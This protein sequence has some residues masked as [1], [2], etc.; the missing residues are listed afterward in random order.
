VS[1][2]ERVTNHVAG[3]EEGETDAVHPSQ[4]FDRV[5]QARLLVLWQVDLGHVA[6]NDRGRAEADAGQEHLHLLDRRVLRLVE[7]DERIVERAAAH[8]RQRRDLDD[9]L[10]QQLDDFLHAEHLVQRVVQRAQ[11]GVDFLG[12]VAGQEAELL[13]GF[14]R[15]ADQDQAL[16]AGFVERFD[17]HR[18]REEGLAGTCRADA[19]VDVMR[20]DRVQVTALVRAAATHGA[21]FDLDRDVLRFDVGRRGGACVGFRQAQVDRRCGKE[22]AGRVV[23]QLAQQP[24]RAADRGVLAGDAE[25]VAA[26]GDFHAVAQF[27]QPQVRIERAAEVGQ[28]LGV[29]GVER[30]FGGAGRVA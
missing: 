27:Q 22:F 1:W 11:V 16:H 24:F 14:D 17:R 25:D 28:P 18:D 8:V 3:L 23:P 2:A 6:G 30:E 21:A 19:E 20:G 13:A 10:F 12:K 9:V 7:D 5:L 26:V 15:G 29:G 4:Y